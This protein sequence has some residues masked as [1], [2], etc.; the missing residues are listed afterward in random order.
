MV[1]DQILTTQEAADFL[2]LADTRTILKLINNNEI[3][4]KKIGRGYRILKSELV[5]FMKDENSGIGSR[6]KREN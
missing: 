2:K 1:E 6:R 5:K 4:A 3:K